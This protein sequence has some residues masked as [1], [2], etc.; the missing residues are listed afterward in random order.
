MSKVT[1][2]Q[3]ITA[4]RLLDR[5]CGTDM[6]KFPK[7]AEARRLLLAGDHAAT[8]DFALNALDT[9]GNPTVYVL[10]RPDD[11]CLY[12]VH[13]TRAGAEEHRNKFTMPQRIEIEERTLED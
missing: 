3:A 10:I 1:Q 2:I 4:V 6:Q 8:L 7:L 12:D 5:A 11:G 9:L 13:R